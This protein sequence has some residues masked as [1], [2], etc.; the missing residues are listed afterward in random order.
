M[1]KR[2]NTSC[3]AVS[4]LALGGCQSMAGHSEFTRTE[5]ASPQ[6][7]EEVYALAA[8][9]QARILIGQGNLAAAAQILRTAQRFP[10]TQAEASNG[11]GVVYA[12]MKRYD[13]ADRYFRQAAVLEPRNPKYAANLAHLQGDVRMAAQSRS[14][15][16]PTPRLPDRR[17]QT[18]TKVAEVAAE[19]AVQQMSEKVAVQRINEKAVVTH[20][21]EIA[22]QQAPS[23]R[24]TVAAAPSVP[25][26]PEVKV[27]EPVD[28]NPDSAAA[29]SLDR[30]RKE[31]T[32]GNLAAAA[33]LFRLA[34]RDA[35]TLADA[36]NG[37]GIVY[38][39]LGRHDL[40]DR[41]MRMA[42]AL[43]PANPRFA[44]NLQR[45]NAEA[46]LA[47]NEGSML[48]SRDAAGT[49]AVTGGGGR[50]D[51][52]KP[53]FGLAPA[54]VVA[55]DTDNVLRAPDSA[56]VNIRTSG[57][58]AGATCADGGVHR[59]SDSVSC[60]NVVS[61]PAPAPTMEVIRVSAEP[62]PHGEGKPL[63]VVQYN[64]KA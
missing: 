19:Y 26:A 6:E 7:R 3:I 60:L 4:L 33:R 51:L 24:P 17:A 56:S 42:A 36:S 23:N 45:L 59:I 46:M 64:G 12:R 21:P 57:T 16:T 22:L 2:L 11:L 27:T 63:P 30:A 20:V 44:A 62:A 14:Q 8:L 10:K 61:A 25:A 34:Q 39:R 40:A 54:K 47:K 35:E 29:R 41:Y 58:S 50:I 9:Y 5:A 15:P 52:P 43:E 49:A 38:A 18:A 53:A 55:A 37:L 32:A 31:L 48:A 1:S 13:L 28:A